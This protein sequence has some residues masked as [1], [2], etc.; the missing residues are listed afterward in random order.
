MFK[1]GLS[2]RRP[3]A[4]HHHI[5]STIPS[6]GISHRIGGRAHSANRFFSRRACWYLGTLRGLAMTTAL[7]REVRPTGLE[8]VTPRSEVWCSIQ[9]SYG[10]I[11]EE[12]IGKSVTV[13][14]A[15]QFQL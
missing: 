2:I 4:P 13:S 14:I 8:P 10:R 7:F 12:T 3:G 5:L 15:S 1:G 9:L 6:Q 11:D